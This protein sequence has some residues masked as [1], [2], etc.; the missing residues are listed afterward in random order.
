MALFLAGKFCGTSKI[1]S[2]LGGGSSFV[3]AQ[4]LLEMIEP[5]PLTNL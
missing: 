3:Y 2:F 4:P 5:N 1:G